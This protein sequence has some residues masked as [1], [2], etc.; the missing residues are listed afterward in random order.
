[1]ASMTSSLFRSVISK[2]RLVPGHL[3]PEVGDQIELR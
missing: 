2:G 3:S 1:M